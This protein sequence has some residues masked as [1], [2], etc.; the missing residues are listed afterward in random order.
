MAAS[1]ASARASVEQ[2]ESDWL[3]SFDLDTLADKAE[4]IM[5]TITEQQSTAPPDVAAVNVAAFLAAI[6]Q[7][8]FR[9][10]RDIALSI[11]DH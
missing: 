4:T 1:S 2:G 5:N 11:K 6:R 9:A 7:A 8:E 3:P 10:L